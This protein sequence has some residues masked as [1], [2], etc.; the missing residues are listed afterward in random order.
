MGDLETMANFGCT[1]P[2]RGGGLATS[3]GKANCLLQNY[4][5]RMEVHNFTLI[6]ETH[7]VAQNAPRVARA[8]FE[9]VLRR[10]WASATNSCLAM[11]KC[12]QRR[13]WPFNSPLR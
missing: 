3:Q 7:Y 2:I 11:A 6:S 5:S 1:L 9:I 10:G 4:I 13:L 12:I 8:L